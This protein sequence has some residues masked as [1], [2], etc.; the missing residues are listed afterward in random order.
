MYRLKKRVLSILLNLSLPAISYIQVLFKGNVPLHFQIFRFPFWCDNI[1][2]RLVAKCM[3][4]LN[5]DFFYF[6]N[7]NF[8]SQSK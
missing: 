3:S 2:Y 8:F 1:K 4:L 6:S 7:F 5:T